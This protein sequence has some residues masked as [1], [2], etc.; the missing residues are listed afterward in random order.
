[1]TE[2]ADIKKLEES[3]YPDGRAWNFATGRDGAEADANTFVDG[4]PEEFADGGGNIF[5]DGVKTFASQSVAQHDIRRA[6]FAELF[7]DIKG[8]LDQ[9]IPDN[10]GYTEEDAAV[11]EREYGIIPATDATLDERKE[12]ILARMSYQKPKYNGTAQYLQGVLRAS[13]FDVYVHEN[14]FAQT[15]IET[16]FGNTV[17]GYDQFGG[18]KVRDGYFEA[19]KPDGSYSDLCI[20]YLEPEKDE[21]RYG[22]IDEQINVDTPLN[23]YFFIGGETYPETADVPE[24]RKSEFRRLILKYKK[25]KSIAVN[26]INY[27]A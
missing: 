17:F 13:G 5:V 2:I 24:A 14:R 15:S 10:E 1:M 22:T 20:T 12:A 25:I 21:E 8:V 4:E 19:V 18:Y 11:H 7:N 23:Y 26:Y 6:I 9:M 27:T 16:Q 3:L